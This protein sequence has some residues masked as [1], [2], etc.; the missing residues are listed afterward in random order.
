LTVIDSGG[1]RPVSG[2]PGSPILVQAP[3]FPGTTNTLIFCT[4]HRWVSSGG[5]G[6]WV[7]G[8]GSHALCVCAFELAQVPS[9]LWGQAPEF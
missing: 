3:S 6:H 5:S 8:Y 7:G 2:G 9:L 1:F 4:F